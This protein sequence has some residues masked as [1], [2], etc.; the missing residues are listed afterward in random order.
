MALKIIRGA[1]N[2]PIQPLTAKTVAVVGFGNQGHAHA[3]NLRESGVEVVVANRPDTPNG[4]R[5]IA[6]GFSPRGIPEAMAG[7]DLVV[8]ALPDEAQP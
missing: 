7:A 2:A 8:L 5:A 4:R 3:L 6:N 1:E